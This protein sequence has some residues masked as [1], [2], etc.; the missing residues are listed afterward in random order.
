[1]RGS[2]TERNNEVHV[3]FRAENEGKSLGTSHGRKA[4]TVPLRRAGVQ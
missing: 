4:V 2:E 3:A 1:M